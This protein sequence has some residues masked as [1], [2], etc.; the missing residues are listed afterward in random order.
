[1]LVIE[2]ENSD[3]ESYLKVIVGHLKSN[4]CQEM[5]LSE[6]NNIKA[7]DSSKLPRNVDARIED[8]TILLSISSIRQAME[9]ISL[10]ELATHLEQDIEEINSNVMN[11]LNNIYHEF[12]HINERAISPNIHSVIEDEKPFLEK[13]GRAS[14]R[15]RV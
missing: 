10:Y 3:M 8:D 6:L 9:S 7:V 2:A 4:L 15:E 11:L 1:M 13:I 12:C 5:N 14:C